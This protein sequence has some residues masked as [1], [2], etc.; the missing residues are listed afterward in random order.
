[1]PVYEVESEDEVDEIRPLTSDEARRWRET[2]IELSVWRVIAWQIVAVMVAGAVAYL[3]TGRLSVMLSAAYG[4]LSVLLPSAVMAWGVTAGRVARLLSAFAK[5]SL[6]VLVFWEGIKVLLVM[7]LL[8]FAPVW[9]SDL[10]WLA[11]VAGLVL[12]L[13]VYWLAFFMQSRIL[14]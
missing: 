6:A 10:N 8:G 1:M 11:L 3:F 7:V 14:K 4:G 2:Q 12:V 5:G 9:V 13:K